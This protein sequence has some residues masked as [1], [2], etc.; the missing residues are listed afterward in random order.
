MFL[1]KLFLI[2]M[3]LRVLDRTGRPLVC[4]SLYALALLTNG[5]IF[6]L[7]LGT[8]WTSVLLAFAIALGASWAFFFLLHA[9]DGTGAPYWAVLALGILALLMIE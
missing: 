4:S 8:P 9:L 5:L 1:L 7:A 2:P 6:D 3:L